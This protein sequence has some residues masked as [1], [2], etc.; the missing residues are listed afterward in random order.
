MDRSIDY[1]LG[2]V[3]VVSLVGLSLI[4]GCGT[5]NNNRS[6]ARS[7]N[8]NSLA[9]DIVTLPQTEEVKPAVVEVCNYTKL[10]KRRIRRFLCKKRKNKKACRRKVNKLL[11]K[12][13]RFPRSLGESND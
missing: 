13:K 12:S 1:V 2:F 8:P 10:N 6:M 3:I 11:R 7:P 5:D 9:V 4:E